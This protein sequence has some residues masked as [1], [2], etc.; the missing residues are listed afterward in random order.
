MLNHPTLSEWLFKSASLR[1]MTVQAAT[2]Q[3][4]PN[5]ICDHE[6]PFVTMKRIQIPAAQLCQQGLAAGGLVRVQVVLEPD[7][8]VVLVITE[9][10]PHPNTLPTLQQQVTVAGQAALLPQLGVAAAP[11]QQIVLE[12]PPQLI[13]KPGVEP[14]YTMHSSANRGL[15][16]LEGPPQMIAKPASALQPV[17][18][19]ATPSV[20]HMALPAS[21]LQMV[22]V[23][24]THAH[25]MGAIGSLTWIQTSAQEVQSSSP[26][27]SASQPAS[28][29]Q[30]V[31]VGPTQVHTMRAFAS[32]KLMQTAAHEVQSFSTKPSALQLVPQKRGQVIHLLADSRATKRLWDSDCRCFHY[33]CCKC[34]STRGAVLE[35][36]ACRDDA[37]TA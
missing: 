13:A 19:A 3:I 16:L 29:L 37:A 11:Y 30:I 8:R 1:D 34:I 28:A 2:A 22:A 27:P 12:G 20:H 5:P 9:L 10:A 17:P 24:S 33:P 4:V 7:H 36:A 35:F 31:A 18:R 14:K 23:R 15:Y 25:A 21:A 32:L 6:D 26:Q